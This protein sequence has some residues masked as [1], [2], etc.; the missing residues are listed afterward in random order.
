MPARF[1][2][3]DAKQALGWH[4]ETDRAVFIRRGIAVYDQD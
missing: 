4:P 3:S 2:C 1:D